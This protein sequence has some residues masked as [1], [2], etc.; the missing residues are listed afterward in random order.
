MPTE[1]NSPL[2][3]GDDNTHHFY[4]GATD[5]RSSV[6]CVSLTCTPPSS[7]KS[8]SPVSAS[9]TDDTPR[10]R[11]GCGKESGKDDVLVSRMSSD[12]RAG[13]V[14]APG[15]ASAYLGQPQSKNLEI[16]SD[17]LPWASFNRSKRWYSVK[18]NKRSLRNM[19]VV[20]V[21]CGRVG[22]RLY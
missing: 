16:H 19:I 13:E 8:P 4:R 18:E 22:A 15:S 14:D 3:E 20:V 7:Q 21:V 1:G 11:E 12:P 10:R 5:R 2:E 9:Y 17:C 6:H